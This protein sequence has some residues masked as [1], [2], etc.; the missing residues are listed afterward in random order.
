MYRVWLPI[1]VRSSRHLVEMETIFKKVRFS[2]SFLN[3]FVFRY[4]GHLF[5]LRPTSNISSLMILLLSIIPF[6]HG[7]DTVFTEEDWSLGQV[8]IR[9][10]IE[11]TGRVHGTYPD[12]LSIPLGSKYDLVPL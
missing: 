2:K 10:R 6:V 5:V 9:S 11:V 4:P 1:L 3:I 7:I 8:C 12:T